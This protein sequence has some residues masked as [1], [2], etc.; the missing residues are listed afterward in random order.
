[1]LAGLKR[2]HDRVKVIFCELSLV[3][4]Y[5]GGPTM[6]ELCHLLAELGYRCIAFGPAF[7]DPRTGQLLQVDGIFVKQA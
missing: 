4:L 3:P 6:F 7:E 1:M 5:A 2:N